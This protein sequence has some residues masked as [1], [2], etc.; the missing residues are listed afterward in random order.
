MRSLLAH[1]SSYIRA[2]TIRAIRH[3]FRV[4]DI[5]SY[6]WKNHTYYLLSPF[7]LALHCI[8]IGRIFFV[9]KRQDK[10]KRQ[11][12]EL[13]RQISRKLSD[14]LSVPALLVK[15]LVS[16]AENPEDQYSATSTEILRDLCKYNK[17]V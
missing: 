1:R 2:A 13:M 3:L 10:E 7:V 5:A 9:D 16:V 14:A 8:Y 12:I 4:M 15:G 6:F 17:I 11:I